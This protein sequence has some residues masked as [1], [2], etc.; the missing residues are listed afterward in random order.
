MQNEADLLDTDLLPIRTAEGIPPA[1]CEAAPMAYAIVICFAS[2][3]GSS[4]VGARPVAGAKRKGTWL[5]GAIL[6]CFR[7]ATGNGSRPLKQWCALQH[8]SRVWFQVPCA[9]QW[10]TAG[11]TRLIPFGRVSSQARLGRCL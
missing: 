6:A 4:R 11:N 10:L 9:K 3:I 2:C 1:V 7:R 8:R 5:D